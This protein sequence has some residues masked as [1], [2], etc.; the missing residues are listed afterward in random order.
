MPSSSFSMEPERVALRTLRA[1]SSRPIFISQPG[2]SGRKLML[3][4]IMRIKMTWRAKGVR[5][6][7]S[8]LGFR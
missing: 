6:A 3:I 2:D 8:L 1:S 7:I 4:P 5:Q